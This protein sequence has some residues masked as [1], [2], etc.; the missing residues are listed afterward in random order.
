MA[1]PTA[2]SPDEIAVLEANSAFYRAFAERDL[3]AMEDL[4]A[5]DAP[6]ACVHPGWDAL[7]GRETVLR[8]WRDVLHGDAPA[9]TCTSASAH[10]LGPV[11]FVVCAE[12]IPGGPPLVAT[13]IF[14]RQG[15]RWRLCHH[16]AG[17]VAQPSDERPPG[18]R[19]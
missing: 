5:R 19:A 9:I 8:S 2:T 3:S 4:W 10:V 13:N 15:N 6:V 18:A 14:L 16:Q 11:A 12:R 1:P 7:R 17:V